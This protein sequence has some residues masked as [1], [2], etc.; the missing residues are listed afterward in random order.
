MDND[1]NRIDK[2]S[3]HTL[4][5]YPTKQVLI[6]FSLVGTV[7]GGIILTMLMLLIDINFSYQMVIFSLSIGI[8]P[9]TLTA[10]YVCYRKI[11]VEDIFN[12]IVVFFT[13][14]VSSIIF[15]MLA[16][17]TL[18]II[19]KGSF[20]EFLVWHNLKASLVIIIFAGILGG[21]CAVL[22]GL[23]ALPKSEIKVDK[24]LKE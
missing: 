14:A 24:T 8:L 23:F 22:T 6:L 13:G 18:Y 11:Y 21:I 9:A 15:A 7:I 4:M 1:G 2:V 19:V 16:I 3:L 10:V 12:S 20:M 17:V 5:D